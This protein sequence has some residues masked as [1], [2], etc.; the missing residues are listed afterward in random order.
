MFQQTVGSY[1][2]EDDTVAKENI[3]TAIAIVC[4]RVIG[5]EHSLEH[6]DLNALKKSRNISLDTIV[7]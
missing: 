2:G 7:Q 6:G 4:S 5:M 3:L 1:G